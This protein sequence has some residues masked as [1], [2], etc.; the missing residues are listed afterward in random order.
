MSVKKKL[1]RLLLLFLMK[2]KK[3]WIILKIN[4]RRSYF[5]DFRE[6]KQ[7][8]EESIILMCYDVSTRW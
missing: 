5:E 4:F 2:R 8:I 7:T 3:T 6:T 1:Y